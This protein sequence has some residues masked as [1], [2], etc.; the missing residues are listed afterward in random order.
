[1]AASKLIE[2]RSPNEA[3]YVTNGEAVAGIWMAQYRGRYCKYAD[4]MAAAKTKLVSGNP[5]HGVVF[6][7]A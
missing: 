1:M 7:R 2:I 5:L 6:Y 4:S 3:V